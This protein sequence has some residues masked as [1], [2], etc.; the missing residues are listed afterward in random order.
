[1]A[2]GL[3]KH[4]LSKNSKDVNLFSAGIIASNGLPASPNAIKVM[5]EM[6]IDISAHQTKQLT[7]ELVRRA[8]MIFVMT[9]WHKLEIIGLLDRPGKEIY[10]VKE[11]YS[12]VSENDVDLGDPIGKPA[13]I[14]RR[15]RDEL[16]LCVP[17]IV[18]KI[19]EK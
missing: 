1:M 5:A 15:C 16:K 9:Q 2:V 10:L 4:A 13:E 14:Y 6:D 8:N 17:G 19:L 7:D 3:V 18:K 12:K 11:F